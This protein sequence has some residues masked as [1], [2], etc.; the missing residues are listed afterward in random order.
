[1]TCFPSAKCVKYDKAGEKLRKQARLKI[2]QVYDYNW[3]ERAKVVRERLDREKVTMKRTNT[4]RANAGATIL[5]R[6]AK[7]WITTPG[8]Q[9]VNKTKYLA[10]LAFK[11]ELY[12]VTD[13]A[14][15]VRRGAYPNK[16]FRV[17]RKSKD[18]LYNSIHKT[19]SRIKALYV[20]GKLNHLLDPALTGRKKVAAFK[21]K[22]TQP[23]AR[24]RKPT[25][26]NCKME[27]ELMEWLEKVWSED[28]R[29]SRTMIFRKALEINPEFRGGAQDPNFIASAKN[30]FY[31]SFAKK[32]DLSI[33]KLS[34]V[35][36]KLPDGWPEMAKDMCGKVAAKQKA[37]TRPDGTV[38]IRGVRDVHWANTDHVPV[39]YESV[40]NY[41]WGKKG[42]GR[43]NAKT[44][45]K[46]KE[47]FTAQLGCI[48]GRQKLIPFIIMKGE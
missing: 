3:R 8:E 12:T 43:R 37:R 5:A 23:G 26:E 16:F 10:G 33:T 32:N 1:M 30:W 7:L 41:T 19:V 11:D 28:K 15:E 18:T 35:G 25:K 2:N 17:K 45:G 4:M 22:T 21:S 29:V 42:S 38:D 34:S 24:G 6:I 48:K 36:Q 14:I 20:A 44:G 31:Y 39:W 46:E 13:I 40:G 27:K 47:R 9:Q